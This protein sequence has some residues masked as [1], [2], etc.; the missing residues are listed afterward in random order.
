M[1]SD[2]PDLQVILERIGKLEAQNRRLS[3]VSSQCS[4]YSRLPS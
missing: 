1:T 2:I 4:P 3:G